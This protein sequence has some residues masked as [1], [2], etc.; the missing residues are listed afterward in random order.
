MLNKDVSYLVDNTQACDRMKMSASATKRR[1][2]VVETMGGLCGY[3][4]TLGGLASG[5]DAAYIYE[6]EF[7][8]ATLQVFR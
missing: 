2:F 8:I 6:E 7:N 1:V 5:A 4:P 3:L